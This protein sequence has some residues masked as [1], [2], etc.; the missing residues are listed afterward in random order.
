MIET[1]LWYMVFVFSTTFHE[2]AHAWAAL[3][4]GDKT[5]YLGGQ[6]SLDPR[7]HIQREPF[8]M[9]VIPII[10][11]LLMG[12]PIGYASAPYDPDWEW[13][14]PKRAG[15]MAAA[16]PAANL[17]I[18]ITVGMIMIIG[19]Q[20]G[21]LNLPE[22]ISTSRIIASDDG[23]DMLQKA[24]MLISMLFTLNLVLFT[25]NLLP[26]P[27]LDGASISALFLPPN[28]FRK[29]VTT[30]RNPIF[31]LIGMLIAWIV[32]PSLFVPV[33]NFALTFIYQWR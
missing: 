15:W 5:A 1:I 20:M 29:F 4:G 26:L 25:F 31:G 16:G 24:C 14:Y 12:W 10:T 23:T 30:L 3:K 27:P 17:L 2:A 8:G 21:F 18:T 11:L 7:P 33:L 13:R 6:V 19:L 22:S 32:F 9:I 28:T